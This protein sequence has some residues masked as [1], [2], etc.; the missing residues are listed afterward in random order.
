MPENEAELGSQNKTCEEGE[1]GRQRRTPASASPCSGVGRGN[2]QSV[3]PAKER[4]QVK[5]LGNDQENDIKSSSFPRV[6]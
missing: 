5:E 1:A 2:A 4:I 6:L 3:H